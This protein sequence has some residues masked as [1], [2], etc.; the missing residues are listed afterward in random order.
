MRHTHGYANGK[1]DGH[2]NT[3]SDPYGSGLGYAYS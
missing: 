3:Y 1:P 2:V